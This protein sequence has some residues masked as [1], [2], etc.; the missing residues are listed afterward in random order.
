MK[1]DVIK[2]LED[3]SLWLVEDGRISAG[4]TL[5]R[6][7][8]VLKILDSDDTENG[9]CQHNIWKKTSVKE[10]FLE[11]MGV[12]NHYYAEEGFINS[13]TDEEIEGIIHKFI[14]KRADKD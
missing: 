14:L 8:N 4:Y 2:F 10:L 11:R 9:L 5:K 12:P 1:E 13:F 3:H 6:A 7:I